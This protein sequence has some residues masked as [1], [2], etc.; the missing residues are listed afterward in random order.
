MA[1]VYSEYGKWN[2]E[3]ELLNYL[4]LTNTN[5]NKYMQSMSSTQ[6]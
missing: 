2:K 1:I 6:L 5:L 4:V 3:N